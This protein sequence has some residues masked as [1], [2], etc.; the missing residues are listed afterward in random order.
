MR[1]PHCGEPIE[2]RHSFCVIC[3]AD[4]LP[5]QSQSPT[6]KARASEAGRRLRSALS[7]PVRLPRRA[8]APSADGDSRK[9]PAAEAD[10]P[11]AAAAHPV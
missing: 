7:Q 2:S 10:G 11:D 8:G 3:G 1:C 5:L 4:L 6:L 9:E